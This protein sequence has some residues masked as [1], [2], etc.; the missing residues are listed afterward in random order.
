MTTELPGIQERCYKCFT[1]QIEGERFC[2]AYQDYAD[3]ELLQGDICPTII[4][5]QNDVNKWKKKD[6][7]YTYPHIIER[8]LEEGELEKGI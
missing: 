4:A 2:G 1:L 5:I 3:L 7:C 6:D 8:L